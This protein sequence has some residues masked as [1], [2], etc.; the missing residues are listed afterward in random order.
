ME[1]SQG[2]RPSLSLLPLTLLLQLWHIQRMDKSLILCRRNRTSTLPTP[3][4]CTKTLGH[5]DIILMR[6]LCLYTYLYPH[7]VRLNK[8]LK[9]KRICLSSLRAKAITQLKSQANIMVQVGVAA[10]VVAFKLAA[11]VMAEVTGGSQTG[12]R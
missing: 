7:R 2:K 11:G 5:R 3:R 6:I 9:V 1:V 10:I 8:Q 4:W 12:V